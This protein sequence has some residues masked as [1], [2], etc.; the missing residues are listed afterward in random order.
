MVLFQ[1][2]AYVISILYPP[3]RENFKTCSCYI[4]VIDGHSRYFK[5]TLGIPKL[6][7]RHPVYVWKCK[8]K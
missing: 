1:I 2:K 7:L 4:S 3:N 5:K 6:A 8:P